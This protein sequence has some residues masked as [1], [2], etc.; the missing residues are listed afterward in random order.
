M[1]GRFRALLVDYGGVMTSSMGRVFAQFCLEAGVDPSRLKH[2]IGD[3]YGG[4]DPEGVMA[5][6]ERGE[7]PLEEFERWM[8]NALSEG[9]ER[10]LDWKG[11]KDRM[12]AGMIPDADMMAAVRR[13]RAFGIRTAL[14]SNSWGGGAYQRERFPEL[15]DQVV[16]SGEIGARKPEPRI[17]L[18]TADRLGVAPQQCVFVDDLLQNVEGAKAAGMEGIVHRSAEFTIPKLEAL[19]GVAL[20][21]EPSV[22]SGAGWSGAREAEI[23]MD[24]DTIRKELR[25]SRS[26]ID[27]LSAPPK[28]GVYVI[29]LKKPATLPV[30]EIPDDGLLYVGSSG[31]LAMREFDTHFESGQSGYSTLRR[32]IGAIL[33]EDLELTAIPRG[34]GPSETNYR[35]YRFTDEGEI[36]L[37]GWMRSNLE[38][39]VAAVGKD[40]ER[41][42]EELIRLLKP[43]L[44]LKGWP[45]P[46]RARIKDLRQKCVIEARL[47]VRSG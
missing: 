16:I 40:Y 13:A 28:T 6:L 19:F 20:S 25:N 30:G 22:S 44:C 39:G 34:T 45:N 46:E 14:V 9:L 32:S 24:L 1:P 47:T 18:L 33:K 37:T 7:I 8:A 2:L 17:Y 4:G 10:P 31:N 27:T 35:N 29:F 23:E 12:N 42:E 5:R 38:V 11:L 26:S 36:E 43:V 21:A 41:V 3:A 15:Y